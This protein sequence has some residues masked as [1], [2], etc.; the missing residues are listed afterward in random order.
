MLPQVWPLAADWLSASLDNCRQIGPSQELAH[1]LLTRL[2]RSSTLDP[3]E[4]ALRIA[5]SLACNHDAASLQQE[6]AGDHLGKLLA[7]PKIV[8]I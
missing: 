6:Y 2:N 5:F 8:C 1:K 7:T 4:P 3:H